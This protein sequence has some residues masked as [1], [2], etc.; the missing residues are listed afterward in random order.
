MKT[1]R[2]RMKTTE[3]LRV[4]GRGRPAC[5]GSAEKLRIPQVG[6]YKNIW[7]IQ[8]RLQSSEQ[9]NGRT[10]V[11]TLSSLITIASGKLQTMLN[12]H[13][14]LVHFQHMGTIRKNTR[15]IRQQSKSLR[16]SLRKTGE[17]PEDTH[18]PASIESLDPT[19]I[20]RFSRTD[21]LWK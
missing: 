14:S 15:R 5:E 12:K 13:Y 6:L 18:V 9:R 21:S 17:L 1:L 10:D 11:K 8:R 2:D 7:N 16:L 20:Y 4:Q 3:R 19:V